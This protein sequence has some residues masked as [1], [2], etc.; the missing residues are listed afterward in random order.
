MVDQWGKRDAVSLANENIHPDLM[1]TGINP[2]AQRVPEGPI[3][4]DSKHGTHHLWIDYA[5]KIATHDIRPITEI[6]MER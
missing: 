4:Q 6:W 3:L 1:G 2:S 5:Q